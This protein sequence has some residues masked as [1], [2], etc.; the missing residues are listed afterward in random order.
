MDLVSDIAKNSVAVYV[1]DNTSIPSYINQ[2]QS[3]LTRNLKRGALYYFLNE[4]IDQLSK[5]ESN[6]TKMDVFDAVNE[7]FFYGVACAVIEKTGAAGL[8]DNITPNNLVNTDIKSAVIT[9]GLMAAT[10]YAGKQ[11][12]KSETW[13]F[14]KHITDKFRSVF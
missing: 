8:V 11:L 2:D 5:G 10:T 13:N 1:V 4:G 3:F 7:T 14:M 12:E 6:L 9:G